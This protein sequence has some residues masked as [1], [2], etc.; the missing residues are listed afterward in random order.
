MT[1]LSREIKAVGCDW[2]T[3]ERAETYTFPNDWRIREYRLE[4]ADP[5]PAR[6]IRNTLAAW[7]PYMGRDVT[8]KELALGAERVVVLVDDLS[9]PTPSRELIDPILDQLRDAGVTDERI[10]FVVA[11]GTHRPMTPDEMEMKLG[12]D[13]LSRFRCE[14]HDARSA[15]PVDLGRTSFG[16]PVRIN[17][18]VGEADLAIGLG[19]I[20]KH[21]FAYASGGAKIFFPGV[22]HVDSVVA[23]HKLMDEPGAKFGRVRRDIDEAARMLAERTALFVVNVTVD[24]AGRITRVYLGEPVEMFER[25]ADEALASYKVDFHRSDFGNSG[26]ADVAFYRMGLNS[27]NPVQIL[28]TIAGWREV[29]RLPVV[30]GDFADGFYYDGKRDGPYEDFVRKVKAAPEP[31]AVSLE[32]IVAS[33]EGVVVFSPN[34]DAKSMQS[35]KPRWFVANGWHRLIG[36]LYELL[37]PNRDAA[38]FHDATLQVL[39]IS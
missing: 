16:T 28:K 15:D 18:T 2:K 20:T 29:C 23:N 7:F 26:R 1:D 13:V 14:N 22:A 19:A 36:E 25:C 4:S 33:G 17:R 39:D 30:I 21:R 34:L 37:G 11:L 9:R 6:E 12:R 5:L 35:A 8:L 38:F 3:R 10:R 27:C 32:A 31:S 24:A